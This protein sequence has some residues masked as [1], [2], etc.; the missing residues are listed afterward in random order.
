MQNRN[1]KDL[2]DEEHIFAYLR[3]STSK[4]EQEDSLIQQEDGIKNIVS[5]LSMENEEIIY[6]AETFSGFENKKRKEFKTMLDLI[7][8]LKTPCV[9]LCRDIS[10]LSRNP[11]DSQ[12]IMDRV[13]GDNGNR[14]KIDRIYTLDYDRVKE[15]S[16]NTDKEEMHKA[17]SASYY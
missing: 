3:R 13:Y 5:R 17:L 12:K 2:S 7:D 10:R 14:V 9:I 4:K 1:Q 15:W 16:R 6:F 8:T 11:S